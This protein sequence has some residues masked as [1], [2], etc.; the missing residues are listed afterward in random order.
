[1]DE[2]QSKWLV[3][4]SA[5]LALLV[6]GIVFFDP[7]A[8][9]REGDRRWEGIADGRTVD[10]V[11]GVTLALDGETIRVMR[12]GARWRWVEPVAVPAEDSRIDALLR[13]VLDLQAGDAINVPPSRV[14][15]GDGSPVVTVE[16]Q[17]RPDLVV[18]IGD[19]APVGSASYIQL[20]EGPV[21]ASRTRIRAAL[22]QRASDLREPALATF[23]RTEV[24]RVELRSGE[25]QPS[26]TFERNGLGW[27]RTDQDPRVKVSEAAIHTLVDTIR[28]TKAASYLDTLPPFD[29]A[30]W[31]LSVYWGDPQEQSVVRLK[32]F[33]DASWH[34]A[35][36]N[37]PGQVVLSNGELAQLVAADEASWVDTRLVGLRP[38]T[39]ER[40]VVMLDGAEMDASRT[41]DGWSDPRAASV[42]VALETGEAVRAGA[43]PPPDG[44][45][46]GR[47]EI[48][49][50]DK[51]TVLTIHQTLADGTRVATE[52]GTTAALQVS[53]GTL[54]ALT[55]ALAQ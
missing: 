5:V 27:W 16:V 8:S 42:L 23:P 13:S 48:H 39:L 15:I 49:Q 37:H 2:R 7:P 51:V 40:M 52:T 25:D 36:P 14:G 6:C 47:I 12:E 38:T 33:P 35:G 45:P 11:N 41:A 20:D 9:E 54:R 24:A 26:L 30:D 31:M 46:T 1:M 19:D 21:R 43:H 44:L 10:Q 22:P 4:L 17:G 32:Q 53:E 50:G 28:F 55:D 34:A 3:V 29:D 18:R